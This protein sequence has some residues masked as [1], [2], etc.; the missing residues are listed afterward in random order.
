MPVNDIIIVQA[1][2]NVC[3][4]AVKKFPYANLT[5]AVIASAI[6]DGINIQIVD[7]YI[8][9]LDYSKIKGQIALITTT[10]PSFPI[11]CEVSRRFRDMGISTIVGGV[12]A[13]VCPDECEQHFDAVAI[14]EA[15]LLI[16]EI[17]KDFEE[18]ILKKKYI[19]NEYFDLKKSKMPR[20]DLL[21]LR[22][23]MFFPVMASKGCAF[24]C[25][26]CSSRIITGAE[27]RYKSVEQ[28]VSEIE[29]LR[30]LHKKDPL[31][32]ASFYFIDSN[33]YTNRKYL[34]ELLN[35]LIPLNLDPWGLFASV[36]I[37]Y[38][39]EV[40]ELLSKANCNSIQMG[41]ESVYSNTLKS[42]NKNQ[43]DPKRYGEVVNKPAEKGIHARASFVFGFD[44]DD[45]RIFEE[46]SQAITKAN[47]IYTG[48]FTLTPFPGTRIY[49]KLSREGRILTRDW[50]K[51]NM[52]NVV[53]KPANL[54]PEEL[55]AGIEKIKK[56]VYNPDRIIKC[57]D[58]FAE[59]SGKKYTLKFGEKTLLMFLY[60]FMYFS[61]K[62]PAK[63]FL[64]K[65]IAG[66]VQAPLQ[67]I[68]EL[69]SNI[70]NI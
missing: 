67:D 56:A 14:G 61:L 5:C 45:N 46:T 34:I 36:N 58:T 10:T 38:D 60:T 39:D 49:E 32:P 20:Y 24:D 44:T 31:A 25:D 3:K 68:T 28:V 17:L 23:Y 6:P 8:E 43:N 11:A 7:M 15:E 35:A 64:K 42:I 21:K 26:F 48:F 55:E 18:G 59:V 70:N 22:K 29:Y 69:L 41:F 19:A 9:D 2:T 51:Y 13:H 16:E 62:P 40:L 12:H 47:I 33:L 53:F 37:A 50:T 4:G 66:K 65:A 1:G 54:T 63:K 57:L 27:F 30:D 52:S